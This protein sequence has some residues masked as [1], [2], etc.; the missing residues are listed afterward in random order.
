M[1]V[2]R[3][4]DDQGNEISDYDLFFL[5]GK[6]YRMDK[7]PKGFF[8]DRQK[9]KINSC[10]LTYYLDDSKMTKITDGKIGFRVVARP[11]ESF[12]YYSPGE[13]RSENI[14]TTD[15]LI[16]NETLMLD[17][18][19]RRHVDV[20]TFIVAPLKD[21]KGSFKKEKPIGKDVK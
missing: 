3:V 11:T 17:I 13:F 8:V 9:N 1:I 19:L 10:H 7:L 21:G 4:A 5:A 12:A 18:E 6:E 15:L 16:G 2:I 20:N 14:A